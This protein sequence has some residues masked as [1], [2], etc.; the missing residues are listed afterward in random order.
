MIGTLV[1]LGLAFGQ[2]SAA[3]TTTDS[4]GLFDESLFWGLGIITFWTLLG[5]FLFPRTVG[6]AFTPVLFTTPIAFIIGWVKHDFFHGFKLL[7]LGF[8]CWIATIII[9]KIRPEAT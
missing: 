3:W 6:F 4:G 1:G 2:L 5:L 9:A 7:I 8:S